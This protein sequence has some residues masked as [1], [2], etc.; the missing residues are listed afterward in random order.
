MEFPIIRHWGKLHHTFIQ[1]T[2]NPEIPDIIVVGDDVLKGGQ[3][4]A[5]IFDDA[6]FDVVAEPLIT[7][8]VF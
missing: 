2:D 1:L 6:L 3:Y 5:Y 8:A 4:E 7:L